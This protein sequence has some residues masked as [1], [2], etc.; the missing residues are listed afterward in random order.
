MY[1]LILLFVALFLSSVVYAEDEVITISI[2]DFPPFE[3]V[4]NGKV[5]G[6]NQETISEVLKRSGYKV[7]F[8]PLPWKRALISTKDGT[9]DAIASIKKS[10]HLS[11]NFIFSDPIM[12]TQEYFFKKTSSNLKL[13]SIKDLQPYKIGTVDQYFYG[14][15][16]HEKDFPKLFP[17]TSTTPEVDNLEKLNA[18]RVDLVLCSVNI[19]NYWINKYPKLFTGIDYIKNP[20]V[21]GVQALYIA[22]SKNNSKD[23]EKIVKKFNEELKK[24]IAE[25]NI[26][27]SIKKY[28]PNNNL[29]IL[30]TESS[31]TSPY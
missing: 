31:Y 22:F 2:R 21:S 18:N 16:F 14:L 17:I 4:E 19:C 7:K 12:Y 26:S 25:G 27:Y 3:F 20:S 11:N 9:I 24:Y 13:V 10:P 6:I 15:N 8:I 1:N 23:S 5:V 30:H 28:D 29:E